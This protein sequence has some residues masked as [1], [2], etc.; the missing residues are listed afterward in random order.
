[1]SGTCN[2]ANSVSGN[3]CCTLRSKVMMLMQTVSRA[4]G[5]TRNEA[6]MSDSPTLTASMGSPRMEPLVSMRM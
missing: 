1:M 4:K 6:I 3:T 2:R 5:S